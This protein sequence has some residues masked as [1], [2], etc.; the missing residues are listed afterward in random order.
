MFALQIL[1]V[2]FLQEMLSYQDGFARHYAEGMDGCGLEQE[3]KV[4]QA[5]YMLVRTLTDAFHRYKR[6]ELEGYVL[7]YIYMFH[8]CKDIL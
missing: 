7:I 3:A 1:V 6:H 8:I 2:L 5:Y 4:R